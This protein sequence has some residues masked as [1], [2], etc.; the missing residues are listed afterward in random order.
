MTKKILAGAATAVLA[1]AAPA[2]A[3]A[4]GSTP[5]PPNCKILHLSIQIT[6]SDPLDICI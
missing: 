5:P 2:A 6:P 3:L 1:L 4:A